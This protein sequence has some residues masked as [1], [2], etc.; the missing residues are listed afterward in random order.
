MTELPSMQQLKNFIIYGTYRNFTVAAEAANITQSAFSSQMKKLEDN[1]G[2]KLIERSNRGSHLTPDGEAFL[3]KVTPIVHELEGCLCDIQRRHGTVQTLSVGTMLSLGDVLMNRHLAYFQKH[4]P[5]AA[6]RVYNMEARA[7][8]QW[9]QEDKLDLVSLY[10]LP[11]MDLDGYERQ[12]VCQEQIVYY[13]PNM[14]DCPSTVDAAYMASHPLAQ[15]SPHYLM[16]ECLEQYFLRHGQA[17]PETQA[18]F[19]TPYAIM[20]YC[21]QHHIGA[22]LPERFLRAMGADAG[23]HAVCPAI[24]VPCYL[25]YKGDNPKFAS[26]KIFMEYMSSI[27]PSRH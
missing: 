18:W 23:I 21:Q 1:L 24:T 3:A 22:L 8:L 12:F 6:L 20:H 13:A 15:Y 19:S 27:Q 10:Y 5:E 16:H 25:V 17:K 4:H 14:T 7:L 2:V 9:L 26:I 11:S